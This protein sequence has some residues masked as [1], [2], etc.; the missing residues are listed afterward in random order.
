MP[1]RLLLS[2]TEQE[3][4]L[5]LPESQ[6]DLI[7]YYSFSDADPWPVGYLCDFMY[8]NT[9]VRV[10]KSLRVITGGER[11]ATAPTRCRST[12]SRPSWSAGS[13]KKCARSGTQNEPV[14]TPQHVGIGGRYGHRPVVSTIINMTR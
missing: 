14:Q 10:T 13:P 7:W 9:R 1:R 3:S 5:A 11:R 12:S 4:L 2:A 8:G 6:D